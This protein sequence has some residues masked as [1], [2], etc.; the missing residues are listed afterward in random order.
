MKL[1][2]AKNYQSWTY[3]MNEIARA[4][5]LR[6]HIDPSYKGKPKII[7]PYE[8]NIDQKALDRW[9][10]WEQKDYQMRQ[11][12][13]IN[14]KPQH[15]SYLNGKNSALEMWEALGTCFKGKGLSQLNKCIDEYMLLNLEDSS[16]LQEYATDFKENIRKLEEMKKT[17]IKHWH[18]YRFIQG[19]SK[20]YELWGYN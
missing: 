4:N 12:I 20:T 8:E 15:H 10:L 18:C 9:Q 14:V 19:V 1:S 13:R 6:P 5:L 11:A 16:D 17:D 2:G 7:D 3:A